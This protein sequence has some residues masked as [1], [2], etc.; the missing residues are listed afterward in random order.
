VLDLPVTLQPQRVP[1]HTFPYFWNDPQAPRLGL[2]PRNG[3]LDGLIWCEAPACYV[4]HSVNAYEAE[5]GAVV[6][7]VVRHPRTHDHDRQGPNE[8]TPVLVRWTLDRARG[9]LTEHVLDDHGV[10]LPRV[11]DRLGGQ[12]DR[13]AYTAAL[14]G[15]Q[16]ELWARLQA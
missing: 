15:R 1:G 14:V 2:L 16:S 9:R 6:V 10:A 12:N 5:G 4:F 13:Y 11:D 8:G 3:D 7:D